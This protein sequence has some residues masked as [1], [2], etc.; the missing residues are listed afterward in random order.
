MDKLRPIVREP[1][2][3]SIY[4]ERSSLSE[5]FLT[6][7]AGSRDID[8]INSSETVSTLESYKNLEFSKFL[9]NGSLKSIVDDFYSNWVSTKV[10]ERI[11]V[12]S[13]LFNTYL[14]V[15]NSEINKLK[16]NYLS[17]PLDIEED[18]KSK[19]L[20]LGLEDKDFSSRSNR[21][22]KFLNSLGNEVVN[23]VL[24]SEG[25]DSRKDLDKKELFSSFSEVI[26]R[27]SIIN[28]MSN[29]TDWDP[30]TL[31]MSKTLGSSAPIFGD[32]PYS[33]GYNE[34]SA[35]VLYNEVGSD[36]IYKE[37]FSLG[38]NTSCASVV[39]NG[40]QL[41]WSLPDNPASTIK[42]VWDKSIVD[43]ARITA[44]ELGKIKI[45]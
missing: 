32:V 40:I 1:S 20:E 38:S 14:Q 29:K 16:D 19:A 27:W 4:T 31:D 45:P 35:T 43:A 17:V 44:V 37:S 18:L 9:D 22:T 13:S 24:I 3:N 36:I 28:S 10:S 26:Y 33:Q 30:F 7:R 34:L 15:E 23:V 25:R 5:V 6:L 41:I 11:K 42:I 2:L 21:E 8:F 39:K 12:K